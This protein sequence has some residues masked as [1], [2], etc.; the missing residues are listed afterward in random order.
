MSRLLIGGAI[1]LLMALSPAFA[2]EKPASGEGTTPAAKEQNATTPSAVDNAEPGKTGGAG[3]AGAGAGG[4]GAG[5][6]GA[7]GAGGA[8]GGAGGAGGGGGGG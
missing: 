2:E 7:G 1:A 6:A 4:A 3:G 5:G 8:G